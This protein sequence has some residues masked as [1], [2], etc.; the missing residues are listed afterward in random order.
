MAKRTKDKNTKQN[1]HKKLS[2]R[3]NKSYK[4]I[5]FSGIDKNSKA[6]TNP[7]RKIPNEKL[8]NFYRTPAKIKLLNLYNSK[9]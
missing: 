4:S 7:N 2:V 8:K 5:K 3:S 6:S 9:P 1:A